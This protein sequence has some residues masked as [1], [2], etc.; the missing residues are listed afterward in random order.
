MIEFP[1]FALGGDIKRCSLRHLLGGEKRKCRAQSVPA[2]QIPNRG[3][4][5]GIQS[6][7]VLSAV[8][9]SARATASFAREF[10]TGSD[11]P[12][13]FVRSGCSQPPHVTKAVLIVVLGSHAGPNNITPRKI[14]T[15]I[16]EVGFSTELARLVH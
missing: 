10:P 7:S 2:I 11:A 8:M 9:S 1:L 15:R 12:L 13:H 16:I 3:G 4:V 5:I 6:I 14:R